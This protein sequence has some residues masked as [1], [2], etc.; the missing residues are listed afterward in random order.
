M[1]TDLSVDWGALPVSDVY[2]ANIPDLFSAKPVVLS[3]RYASGGAGTIRLKGKM[4]GQEFVR[5]IPVK[6]PET[7]ADHDVLA[8][9]WARRKVDDLMGQIFSV[10]DKVA[11]EQW[12][13][14]VTQVG[15]SFKLMT[16]Y[17]SFVA[18]DD[19]I[20]TGGDQPQRVDVPTVTGIAECVT[21][22][23]SGTTYTC[24][25]Y[26]QT[27][28]LRRLGELPLQ[29][30]S[31]NGLVT[32]APGAG[33]NQSGNSLYRVD[34]AV[35]S[36]RP[37]EF[38]VDGVS[39]NFGIAAGGESPGS[40]ASGNAP[41]LTASGG[42]NGIASLDA[43]DELNIQ[44]LSTKPENGSGV[45]VNVRTRAGTNEFH[46]SA[47]HFFGNDVFDASDWF[48]NSR[49]LEQPAKRLNLFG[50]SFGGPIKRDH[51]FFFAAYE[52]LRL[53]QP[54]VGITDVPSV[55]AR[56]A[57]PAGS[58][59]N[60]FPLPTGSAR[61]DGF[62]EFAASF[63]NPARHDVG[64]ARVEHNFASGSKLLGRYSFADSE[65]SE[66]GA[67]G[68]SLN[69][70]NRIRTRAQTFTGMLNQIFSPVMVMELQANY[71]RSTVSGAYLLDNFGG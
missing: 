32:L 58:F 29:G 53:R 14:E 36:R 16:Q 2:P 51:A 65:T 54:L 18:I 10:Q 4:A 68:F 33:S 5:E 50:G 25:L 66:R 57:A 70:T 46:G 37:T 39:A 43:V 47:F 17:T 8:T 30:R 48:A 67:N 26:G 1:L 61:A 60:A 27:I 24:V 19:L 28:T 49:G 31:F 55:A 62:A 21:I 35:N 9:L 23:G 40:S 3:G 69:T 63:A 6:L 15:L 20:F 34:L 38:K 52:G 11:Q 41:A 13:E 22:A 59:L 44:T 42:T 56:A 12:Q 64:S 7:E 71:S 45:Q